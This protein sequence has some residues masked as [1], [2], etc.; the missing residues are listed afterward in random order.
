MALS[1]RKAITNTALLVVSIVFCLLL[2]EGATRVLQ[3][4]GSLPEFNRDTLHK[5]FRKPEETLNAK[6]IRSDNPVLFHEYDPNDPM[7]NSVGHRGAEFPLEKTP[8][9]LRI[10]VLGDSVAYGFGVALEETFP[11]QLQQLLAQQGQKVEVLN[12]AVSGYG[13]AA[14]IE[15]FNSKVQQY[16]PDL[17]LLA[18]VLNDPLPND[19]I[20]TVLKELMATGRFFDKLASRTQFGAWLYLQYYNYKDQQSTHRNYESI[21]AEQ[22]TWQ[23]LNAAIKHLKEATNDNFAVA[24]F[25]LL[26][27]FERYPFTDIHQ[28]LLNAFSESNVKAVDMLPI[29]SQH[30]HKTLRIHPQDNTHPNAQGHEVAAEALAEFLRAEVL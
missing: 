26:L 17:V 13:T 19:L 7:V 28:Q 24:V 3:K 27:D 22:K 15:L 11:L 18:Y 8:G 12:F 16:K 4:A 1:F 30:D 9:T 6:T 29:Y 2:A 23:E 20:V 10:A 5:G 25:P 21:F 14:H